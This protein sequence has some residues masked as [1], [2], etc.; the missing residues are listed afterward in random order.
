MKPERWQQLDKLFHSALERKPEER[1]IFLDEA[2]ASDE[3]LRKEVQELIAAHEKAGSFIENPALEVEAE[4]YEADL[5]FQPRT[6][7]HVK[8]KVE[9][10]R[11][12]EVR[13]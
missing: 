7:P 10:L 4:D 9:Q 8:G 12:Q 11:L 2:C 13:I 5:P 1:K 3:Q 6:K